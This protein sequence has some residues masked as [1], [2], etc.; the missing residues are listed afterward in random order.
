MGH[1]DVVTQNGGEEK[2]F[3]RDI[4]VFTAEAQIRFI[5]TG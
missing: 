1:A 5:S 3:A 4:Y 2:Y